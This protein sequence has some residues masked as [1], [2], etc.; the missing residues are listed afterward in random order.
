MRT[1]EKKKKMYA[2]THLINRFLH[3][4]VLSV[5][6]MQKK[7]QNYIRTADQNATSPTSTKQRHPT[8]QG[9]QLCTSSSWHYQIDTC[10]TSRAS[11]FCPLHVML[12]LSP[13]ASVAGG[14]SR[15]QRG[16]LVPRIF[17]IFCPRG[18]G[19]GAALDAGQQPSTQ[20]PTSTPTC[21]NFSRLV[22]GL[23]GITD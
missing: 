8:S 11:S 23:V 18:L 14:V 10:P 17:F 9:N 2:C 13:F 7:S 3:L 12:S 22:F 5:R 20:H 19:P 16:A 1:E 6:L 21:A 15:P 4:I